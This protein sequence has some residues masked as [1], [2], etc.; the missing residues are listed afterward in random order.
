MENLTKKNFFAYAVHMYN[1]PSCAGPA[2][3]DED[4]L[5][6]KY[7]KR[8]LHKYVRTGEIPPRLL[9]NHLIGVGNV[10][11]PESISRMLFFRVHADAW[12]PLKTAL[13][14]LNFMPDVVPVVNGIV[15]INKDIPLDV[16]LWNLL[17][18]AVDN[19]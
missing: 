15:V 12:S 11:R 14:F 8:L 13:E 2:E 5:R 3:F 7:I 1:N 19:Q 16:K 18:E 10:F 17:T 9:L 6:I 4:L